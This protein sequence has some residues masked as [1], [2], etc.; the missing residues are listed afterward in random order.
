MK[1]SN[2]ELVPDPIQESRRYVENA[3]EVLR[4]KGRLNTRTGLY[5]DE[6][7]VK[8]AGNYL[9]SG[10]LIALDAVFQVKNAKSMKKG[11]DS[12]V[13]IDD[14]IDAVR[15]R[16]RK[17]LDWV[18]TGYKVMHLSMTYDGI[19][20]KDIC[21]KGFSLADSIIDRCAALMN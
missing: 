18:N 4:E 12:R 11:E 8:A 15:R 7:Y 21:Q 20:D 13:G 10:V 3:K 16:D 5:Q 1:D 6:K 19:Q 2:K 17:L 14:Y 9:W